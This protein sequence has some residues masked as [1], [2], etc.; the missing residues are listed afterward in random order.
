[1]KS[2]VTIPDEVRT[3]LLVAT[4]YDR[5]AAIAAL[6]KERDELVQQLIERGKG[7]YQDADG[8]TATVVIPEAGTSLDLYPKADLEALCK[9][10]NLK[11]P[12]PAI[13]RSFRKA[14]EDQARALAGSG[15]LDLFDFLAE[16]RPKEGFAARAD[17]LLSPARARDLVA[18]CTVK[19]TAAKPHVKLN[20]K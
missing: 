10:M 2:P 7:V 18:M 14:R 8:R 3:S 12:T 13:L 16:Y 17:A 19:K 4:I 15:F 11:K 9:E 5:E 6:E 1:M 20:D